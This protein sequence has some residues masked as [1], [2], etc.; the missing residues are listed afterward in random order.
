M[1][2]AV[3]NG[4]YDGWCAQTGIS[5][6]RCPTELDVMLYSSYDEGMPVDFQD[7]DWPKINYVLNHKQGDWGDV[8]DVIWYYLGMAGYPSDPDAVAMVT[9][10][11][12]EGGS[13]YPDPGQIIAILMDAGPCQQRTFFEIRM[14]CYEGFTPGWWKNHPNEWPNPPYDPDD[15][16][17]SVFDIPDSSPADGIMDPDDN[18]RRKIYTDDTLMDALRYK[19]GRGDCGAANILLRAATAA[20]LN[21]ES[22]INYPKPTAWIIS[23][24][25][26]A[27]LSGRWDMISL[28]RT[29]DTW[30]NL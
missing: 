22:G 7:P 12:L 21:A 23:E 24:V 3:T 1:G 2:Y 11:D 5:I 9:A 8:Q 30:N 26:S 27:L 18:K 15:E 14:P 16:I 29:L 20:I 6:D 10:A 28:A 4:E 25:N 17:S 19:G 13:F